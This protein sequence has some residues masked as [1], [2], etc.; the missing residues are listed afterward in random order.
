MDKKKSTKVYITVILILIGIL[1]A[2]LLVYSIVSCIR[3]SKNEKDGKKIV[4]NQ[5]YLPVAVTDQDDSTNVQR[6]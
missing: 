3:M 6:V 2:V 1:I 5:K 4:G